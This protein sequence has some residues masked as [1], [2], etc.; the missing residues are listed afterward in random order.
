M[1]NESGLVYKGGDDREKRAK[2]IIETA[3]LKVDES[4]VWRQRFEENQGW[5][6]E[7]LVK[8]SPRELG[9]AEKKLQDISDKADSRKDTADFDAAQDALKVVRILGRLRVASP[10]NRAKEIERLAQKEVS[11]LGDAGH[12]QLLSGPIGDAIY[13]LNNAVYGLA[14]FKFPKEWKQQ[15]EARDESKRAEILKMRD[16]LMKKSV[17]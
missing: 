14:R 16:E 13:Q 9:D 10:E 3:S 12:Q 8:M 5:L 17:R 6:S 2:M 4:G 15:E 11:L 7:T 1:K